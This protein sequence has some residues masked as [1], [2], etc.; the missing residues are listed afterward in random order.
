MTAGNISLRPLE[1]YRQTNPGSP[2][3][4]T[5]MPIADLAVAISSATNFVHV[6]QNLI[7]AL[8]VTNIGPDGADNVL[9]VD[10]LP[11]SATFLS[12][13]TS[14]GTY[15]RSNDVVA[16]K[17]GALASAAAATAAITLKFSAAGTVTNFVHVNSA[18]TD[19]MVTNDSSLLVIIATNESPIISPIAAKETRENTPTLPIAFTATDTETPAENLILLGSSSNTNLVPDQNLFFGGTGRHRTLI[20]V[21]S[22]NEIGTTII[23]ITA[24]DLDG[25]EA[26]QSFVLTVLSSASETLHIERIEPG[27]APLSIERVEIAGD[28]FRFY[29]NAQAGVPYAVEYRE[30]ITSGSWQTLTNISPLS[31]PALM[32]ISDAIGSQPQRFYRLNAS[33]AIDLAPASSVGINLSFTAKP[34]VSYTIEYCDSLHSGVWET[35][36]SVSPSSVTSKVIISDLSGPQSQRFYRLRSN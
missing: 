3:N 4:I 21:P 9:L 32:Q 18:S 11:A 17:F 6:E 14:Q 15:S 36:T 30:S 24:L 8:G 22:P 35:L 19:P 28:V 25:G 20:A 27:S 16:F 13:Q 33:P 2:V 26:S 5:V 34:G 31:V 12:A 1:A 29:F 7:L 23:T 10:R